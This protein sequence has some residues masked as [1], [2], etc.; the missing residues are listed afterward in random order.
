VSAGFTLVVTLVAMSGVKVLGFS[1]WELSD[2]AFIGGMAYGIY[3]R[4]RICAV[5]ML[6]YFIAS[7]IIISVTLGRPSGL[8]MGLVFV[9]FFWQGVV[10][11]FEYHKL[12][13][14]QQPHATSRG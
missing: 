13:K 4:S 1:A 9:Y 5:L 6:L 8:A 3:R 11:T 12:E 10:G 2:V 7:K 14:H